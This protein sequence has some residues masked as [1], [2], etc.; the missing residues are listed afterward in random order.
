MNRGLKSWRQAWTMDLKRGIDKA[1]IAAVEE[2]KAVCAIVKTPSD[3]RSAL[4]HANSD[5]GGQHHRR[6]DGKIE[7]R[8]W[9]RW[10]RSGAARRAGRGRRGCSSTVVTC[11]LTSSNNQE[12]GSVDLDNPFILLVD[13]KV[14][15]IQ[16]FFPVLEGVAKASRPLLIVAEDVEGSVSNAGCEQHA[17]HRESC[18][19]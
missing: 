3:Y 14:S 16:N 11:L 6:S 9:S 12:A 5:V 10:R 8:R 15:N 19:G 4:S 1:V 13:K 7:P 18:C 17:W 2:L